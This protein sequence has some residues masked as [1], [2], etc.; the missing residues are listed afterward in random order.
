MKSII[1]AGF[2]GIGKSYFHKNNK[3]KNSIDLDFSQFYWKG[4]YPEMGAHPN[5]PGNYLNAIKNAMG[6]YKY[7][8]V[9]SVKDLRDILKENNIHFTL[10][11]P[12][13]LD[14]NK[15]MARFKLRNSSEYFLN[16]ID[17]NWDLWT[18][19]CRSE[20][21]GCANLEIEYNDSKDWYL[22]DFIDK[23]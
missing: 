18:R 22:N 14:K 21:T 20:W 7:I 12:N 11:Y 9:S 10:V 6:K 3:D 1:I 17:E 2:P 13:Q 15:Y 4:P 19:E 16:L 5:W 8:L 23:I